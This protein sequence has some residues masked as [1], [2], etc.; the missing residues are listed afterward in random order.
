MSAPLDPSVMDLLRGSAMAPM[1][2]QPIGKVLQNLGLP[3]LPELPPAPPLPG[4]PPLPVIDL[5]LLIKPLTDLSA[6]FGTGQF[7]SQGAPAPAP[8]QH[9]VAPAP[10]QGPGAPQG[11]AAPV[12]P[13]G[14]TPPIDPTQA[15]QAI[16]TG[17]Q[18]VMQL[19]MSAL[20]LVMQLWQGQGAEQ[21]AA[22][23]GAAQT[24]AGHLATQSGQQKLVL[25][26]ASTSVATGAALMTA[27]IGKFTTTAALTAP[28]L[29]TPPGAAFLMESAIESITE[30]LAITAKTRGEMTIHSANMTHAG[31]KVKV[32]NAPTGV[33]SME[34]LQ[35]LMQLIQPLAQAATTGAQ[36]AAKLSAANTSLSAPNSTEKPT[37]KA[38]LDT[39][40]ATHGGGG[41]GGGGGGGGF[42]PMATPLSPFTGT[43]VAGG[44]GPMTGPFGT[45]AAAT[46][47]VSVTPTSAASTA[48]SSPG[49]MPMGAGAAGAAGLGMRGGG[50][51]DA[52][53]NA[54]LVTS[55][56]GDE[57]VGPIE[58]VSVPV[59]GAAGQATEPP[60][61]KELTL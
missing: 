44:V 40:S 24:D 54:N 27:V 23:Q 58:G 43:R 33:K 61:D 28:F 57:V 56:H 47:P 13:P 41:V 11:A 1:L 5:G 15:L 7:P 42:S 8:T 25:G 55:Q 46:G 49:M 38:H 60:P 17:M 21:A 4:M 26:E 16:S 12:P 53:Q 39:L 22:K 34:G 19:G 51:S 18:T 6:A 31:T 10:E 50:T 20:Q 32:T 59:V 30:G 37:D 29:G 36:A 2:D 35:Q 45:A 52:D 14:Q 9:A 3:A 48:A